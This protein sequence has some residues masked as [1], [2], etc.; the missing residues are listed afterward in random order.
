MK[1]LQDLRIADMADPSALNAAMDSLLLL[2]DAAL[3][4]ALDEQ[5]AGNAVELELAYR[6]RRAL[7]ALSEQATAT[8]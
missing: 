2:D 6:L 3:L 7:A 1:A 4:A 8:A 5:G